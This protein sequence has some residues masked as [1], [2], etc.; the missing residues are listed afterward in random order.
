M[1]K[2]VNC[3]LKDKQA[4]TI[5]ECASLFGIGYQKL[6]RL[7]KMTDCPFRLMNGNRRMI[8]KDRFVQYLEEVQKI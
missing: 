4:L 7:L 8:L 6:E 1:R 2:S 5:N 3:E